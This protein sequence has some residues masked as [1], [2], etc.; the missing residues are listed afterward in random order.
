MEEIDLIF[1]AREVSEQTRPSDVARESFGGPNFRVGYV[2]AK[3]AGRVEELALEIK[4]LQATHLSQGSSSVWQNRRIRLVCKGQVQDQKASTSAEQTECFFCK[5][6]RPPSPLNM[7]LCELLAACVANAQEKGVKIRSGRES[8][9][10][11]LVKEVISLE[12][13]LSASLEEM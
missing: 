2:K 11:V 13:D 1:I 7:Y 3:R 6:I 9:H 10:V 5:A 4:T 8:E 12:I